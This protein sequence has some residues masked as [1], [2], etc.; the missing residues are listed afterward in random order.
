MASVDQV[1]EP[2]RLLAVVHLRIAR[3]EVDRDVVVEREEV[4]E[5]LLDNFALVAEGDDEFLE[6]VRGVQVE[7]M[8][9]NRLSADL[10]HGL[11]PQGGLFS[12]PR[13]E[14]TSKNYC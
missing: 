7:Q 12:E 6:P 4:E 1:N 11:W 9:E 14:T 5:V 10:Y 8:P 3:T 2:W 13:S